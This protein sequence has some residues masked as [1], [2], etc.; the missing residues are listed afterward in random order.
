[1][2]RSAKH[3][4]GSFQIERNMIAVTVFLL[5]MNTMD[6]RSAHNR[7][8]ICYYGHISF[9]SKGIQYLV[10]SVFS[11]SLRPIRPQFTY[12]CAFTIVLLNIV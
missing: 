11:C 4:S 2:M 1:M 8:E 6:F 12:Y 3:I 9:N 10:L 7:E 5:D